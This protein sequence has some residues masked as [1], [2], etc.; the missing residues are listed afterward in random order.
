MTSV[1]MR[2]PGWVRDVADFFF[3]RACLGCGGPPDVGFKYLCWDCLAGTEWLQP[4]MCSR[5]GE[6]V[7]GRVDRGYECYLCGAVKRYFD[8][9]RSAAR[10]DGVVA[11]AMQTLKYSRGL[12]MADDL[13]SF[14]LACVEAHYD[15]AEFDGLVPV[16]L[17]ATRRRARGFNQA[18][19]LAQRLGRHLDKPVMRGVLLRIRHTPSQTNLTAR[20]R[21]SNVKDAFTTRKNHQLQGRKLLL[22][23]DIMTT[24]ATVSE[25]ALMLKKG[26]AARVDVV[27]VARG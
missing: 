19:T 18:E 15:V 8:L 6:P 24:G 25:C 17:Y 11:E 14:L 12:W 21:T 9:A 7:A 3:P 20:Q 23:D 13:A 5:C 22:L 2:R 4:P 26:G 10:Y 16:P 1:A 27:T